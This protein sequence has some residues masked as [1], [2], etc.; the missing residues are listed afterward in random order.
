MR[1]TDEDQAIVDRGKLWL[2]F[3]NTAWSKDLGAYLNSQIEY[4]KDSVITLTLDKD[5]ENAKADAMKLAGFLEVKHFIDKGAVEEMNE[6][7]ADEQAEKAYNKE[8]NS[9]V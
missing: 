9:H 6:L 5:F 4:L 2:E 1:R 3:P 8:V 7:L